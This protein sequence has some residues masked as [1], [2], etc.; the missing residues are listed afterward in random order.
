MIDIIPLHQCCQ[1]SDWSMPIKDYVVSFERMP[2]GHPCEYDYTCTCKGF[3]FRGKC[4]H[5]E[6]AKE[7]HCTWHEQHDEAMEEEGKCP[8]CGGP[9][10][11]VMCGV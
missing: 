2:P 1:L 6:E 3:Q 5:I 11:V 4:K 10:E 7:H 8:R 9:T